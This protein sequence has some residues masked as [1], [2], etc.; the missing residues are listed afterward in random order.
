MN[1]SVRG[2]AVHDEAIT[3]RRLVENTK[4]SLR[5]AGTRIYFAKF[6]LWLWSSIPWRTGALDYEKKGKFDRLAIGRLTL[7]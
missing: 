7:T 6:N 5:A 4:L 1:F 3:T 2:R